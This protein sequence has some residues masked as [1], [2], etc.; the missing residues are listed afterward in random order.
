M[1][2]KIDFQGKQYLVLKHLSS[3]L[4]DQFTLEWSEDSMAAPTVDGAVTSGS[5][6]IGKTRF[7][8][9][10][11]AELL[12]HPEHQELFDACRSA[13]S[14]EP[15]LGNNIRIDGAFYQPKE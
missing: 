3:G 12:K 4:G 2:R 13:F 8:Y 1:K 10:N 9:L 6:A 5:A 15:S 11:P 14:R 7:L